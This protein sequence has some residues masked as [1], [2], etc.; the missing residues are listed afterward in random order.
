[1]GSGTTALAAMETGRN[2]IG[3]EI[4]KNFFDIAQGRI[5]KA[6]ES[7]T[8]GEMKYKGE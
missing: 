2:F 8:S 5:T 3:F 1:M 6:L 4:D 7:G